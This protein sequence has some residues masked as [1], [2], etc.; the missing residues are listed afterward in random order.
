M[1]G[2]GRWPFS[3]FCAISLYYGLPWIIGLLSCVFIELT[4]VVIVALY[5]I[6]NSVLIALSGALLVSLPATTETLFFLFTADG[7]MISIFLDTLGV[8]FSRIEEKN[9][10]DLY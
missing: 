2:S 3:L 8:Y 10:L 7:C 4:I 6:E 5:K 1:L 9:Y